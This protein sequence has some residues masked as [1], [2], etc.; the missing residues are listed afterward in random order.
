M[1]PLNRVPARIRNLTRILL[2]LSTLLLSTLGQIAVPAAP[3]LAGA[4]KNCASQDITVSPVT[5]TTYLIAGTATTDIVFTASPNT[6]TCAMQANSHIYVAVPVPASG[7]NWS[8]PTTNATLAT[9]QATAS[10]VY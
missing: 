3:A 7:T 2:A 10:C 9:C 6:N 5:P 8:T 1:L 4:G